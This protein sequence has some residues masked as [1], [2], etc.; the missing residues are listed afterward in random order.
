MD[1]GDGGVCG[2]VLS[3]RVEVRCKPRCGQGV[4]TRSVT[5]GTGTSAATWRLAAL[6]RAGAQMAVDASNAD[7]FLR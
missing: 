7:S 3:Y 4:I 2:D 1:H 6:R 5:G